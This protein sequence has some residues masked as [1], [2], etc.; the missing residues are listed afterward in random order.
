MCV[1]QVAA[2][3]FSRR[4]TARW[5]RCAFRDSGTNTVCS[6]VCDDEMVTST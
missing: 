2:V 3:H 4:L 5:R 6:V 1:P